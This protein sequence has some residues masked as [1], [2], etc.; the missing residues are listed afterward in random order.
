MRKC[1]REREKRNRGRRYKK[2]RKGEKRQ[3]LTPVFTNRIVFRKRSEKGVEEEAK[4][5]L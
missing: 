4:Q 2:E 3:K 1:V 5:R